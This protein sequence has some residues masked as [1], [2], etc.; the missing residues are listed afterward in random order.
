MVGNGVVWF[1]WGRAILVCSLIRVSRMHP[2]CSLLLAVGLV[3][4]LFFDFSFVRFVVAFLNLFSV[5]AI[6]FFL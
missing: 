6:W 4:V 1:V 5:V 3:D 2:F